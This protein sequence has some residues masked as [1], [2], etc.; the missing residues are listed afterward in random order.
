MSLDLVPIWAAIIVM[1]SVVTP[2]VD[3]NVMERWFSWPNLA[4][5][6]PVPLVTGIVAW[7]L[8]RALQKTTRAAEMLPFFAAMALFGLC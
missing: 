3:A 8:W 2:F 4:F 7:G 6:A 5:W 1:V